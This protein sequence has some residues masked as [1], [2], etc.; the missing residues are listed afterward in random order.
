MSTTC[1]HAYEC[2]GTLCRGRAYE[3][4]HLQFLKTLEDRDLVCEIGFRQHAK[5]MAL[6]EALTLGIGSVATVQRRLRRLRQLGVIQQQRSQQDARAVELLL[7]PRVLKLFA[8]YYE[9][10]KNGPG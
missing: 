3:K 6:K 8:R 1:Q 9:L 7:S 10:V 4:R 2:L 5:P